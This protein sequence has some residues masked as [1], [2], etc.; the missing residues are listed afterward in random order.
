M[1]GN[2]NGE[3]RLGKNNRGPRHHPDVVLGTDPRRPSKKSGEGGIRTPG[4]GQ[5]PSRDFQSRPFN[6]SGTSPVRGS[7][8]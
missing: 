2:A 4:R 8:G 5:P 7:E 1:N 6:R 3:R